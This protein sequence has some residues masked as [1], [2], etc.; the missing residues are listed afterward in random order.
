[1]WSETDVP[2][3]LSLKVAMTSHGLS[4]NGR[5]LER[6]KDRYRADPSV[7]E[8]R[9]LKRGACFEKS[10]TDKSTLTNDEQYG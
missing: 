7:A 2:A 8:C 3:D 6:P 4:T 1:M 9:S 10:S 5:I